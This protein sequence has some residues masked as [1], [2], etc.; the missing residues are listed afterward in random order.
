[1]VTGWSHRT[2]RSIGLAE[3]QCSD[4]GEPSSGRQRGRSPGT[5]ARIGVWIEASTAS[6]ADDL[7]AIEVVLRVDAFE[8]FP[9]RFDWFE[10][11]ERIDEI[12]PAGAGQHRLEAFRT[13]GVP[14]TRKV[15]EVRGMCTEQHGHPTDATVQG[16]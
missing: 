15:L 4:G 10:G 2:E 5:G 12:G 16:W 1:M 3:A 7:D 6:A 11:D 13:F 9:A 14:R 8:I